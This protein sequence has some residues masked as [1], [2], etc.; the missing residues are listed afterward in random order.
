MGTRPRVVFDGHLLTLRR[1]SV[2]TLFASR[3]LRTSFASR[4]LNLCVNSFVA[5]IRVVS[6]HCDWFSACRALV[7]DVVAGDLS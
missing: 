3:R 6:F 4:N 7:E 2:S 5:I 1:L